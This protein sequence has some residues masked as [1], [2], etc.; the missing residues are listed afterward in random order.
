MKKMT[1]V[2]QQQEVGAAAEAIEPFAH[3]RVRDNF[4]LFALNQ[5]PRHAR[6]LWCRIEIDRRGHCDEACRTSCL[7]TAQRDIAAKGETGQPKLIL[8][9]ARAQPREHGHEIRRL[10]LAMIKTALAR[11]CSA[12]IEAKRMQAE[13]VKGARQGADYLVVHGP[14]MKRMRMQDHGA[15]PHRLARRTGSERFDP[16]NRALYEKGSA[17]T[18]KF[19]RVSHAREVPLHQDGNQVGE[20]TAAIPDQVVGPQ[21]AAPQ[22]Q[23]KIATRRDGKNESGKHLAPKLPRGKQYTER[24]Q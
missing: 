7:G 13:L 15:G 11:T 21:C 16:A 3:F 19:A 1:S 23:Q 14:A 6:C 5:Q 20:I 12:K 4:V 2:W 10:A 9:S 24:R 22:H 8:R 17:R 18:R